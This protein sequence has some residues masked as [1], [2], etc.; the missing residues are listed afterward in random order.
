[1]SPNSIPKY[2]KR[3]LWRERKWSGQGRGA[4][5]GRL[6][7]RA[8]AAATVGQRRARQSHGAP[9][10][11]RAPPAFQCASLRIYSPRLW[12][13]SRLRMQPQRPAPSAGPARMT[14]R[15][16]KRLRCRHKSVVKK[17][18]NS[19]STLKG[20]PKAI[21]WNLFKEFCQSPRFKISSFPIRQ[22]DLEQMRRKLNLD[23]LFDK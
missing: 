16:D 23:P 5:G 13:R 11:R 3:P 12:S 20:P 15:L 7:A 10:P 14:P 4:S 22:R 17:L 8:R 1:M 18:F 9:R 19:N 6:R 2:L 21:K